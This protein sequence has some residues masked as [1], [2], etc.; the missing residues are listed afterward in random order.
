MTTD[1]DDTLPSSSHPNTDGMQTIFPSLPICVYAAI[2]PTLTNHVIDPAT[3][4][5]TPRGSITLPSRMQYAWPHG[6]LPILY[7]GCADRGAAGGAHPFNLCALLRDAQGN[8]S[9]HGT[10]APLPARPIHLTVDT[11]NRHVLVA[12]SG[13]PGLTVHTLH[14]DGTIGDEVPPS[15]D[16][17]FG[18]KPHQI[19][20]LPGNPDAILVS[21]GVKGFGKSSYIAGAFKTVRFDGGTIENVSSRAPT[22][23]QAPRGFNPR[24]IDFHPSRPWIYATLEGQNELAVFALG[25]DGIDPAPLFNHTILEHPHAVYKSQDGG[26]VHVHPA[27]TH[28]YVANRN[29]S[30]LDGSDGPAWLTPDPIATFAG[31]ENSVAVFQLNPDTGEPVLVQHVDTRGLHARTIALDKAGRF[32]VAAN[33]APML[34]E[35]NGERQEVPASLSIFRIEDNGLLTF[36]HKVDADVAPEKLW[37]MGVL[38]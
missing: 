15:D 7:A 20:A 35:D 14:A 30:A 1:A 16:F 38:G 2:G 29:D 27:G 18:S 25:Q 12:Y 8:L 36:L 26:E 5:L 28:V 13:A 33:I 34:V 9:L 37:W 19:R 21:R 32:L 31:G 23:A 24:G 4:S 3:G 17:E 10:T 22:D 6:T 11:D